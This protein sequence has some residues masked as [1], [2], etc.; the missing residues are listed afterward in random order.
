[1]TRRLA[2][3]LALLSPLAGSAQ[4][5]GQVMISPTAFGPS[6]CTST[7]TSVSLS[8]TS[9]GTFATGDTFSVYVD[10]ATTATCPATATPSG[11]QLATGLAATTASGSYPTTGT[12]TRKDFITKAGLSGCGAG[13]IQVCVQHWSSAGATGTAKGTAT[14]SAELVVGPASI[15]VSVTVVPGDSALFVSWADGK[16]SDIAAVSYNVTAVSTTP[17][18]THT[19]NFTSKTNQRLSGL[20]NGVTYTVTVT[21][22]SG[23]G[24]ES[25]PSV[26]AATGTPSPVAGFWE[27]Y[28]A[29][30]HR[31]QGGCGG[32]PAGLVSLL[33][34]ALALRG[35]RRRS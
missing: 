27:Q 31:E 18:E 15:P 29:Q 13:T 20:T 24:I 23:G 1:M 12:L 28:T 9:S 30:D 19:A 33:G 26:T 7:S 2:L 25:K 6:D 21:S 14:G 8:W 34:V 11:T 35:L 4:T 16:D 3:I 17:P 5:V 32:G 22:V 10:S